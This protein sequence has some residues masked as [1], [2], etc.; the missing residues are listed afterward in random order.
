M[1]SIT[2]QEAK[3][4]LSRLLREVEGG[5]TIEIR[6]GNRPVAVLSSRDPGLSFAELRGRFR[7]EVRIA[8][9][10]GELD[11]EDARAFGLTE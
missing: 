8:E 6:R 7:G 11:A 5:E 10:F 1:R 4:H 3:T 2:V 9:D